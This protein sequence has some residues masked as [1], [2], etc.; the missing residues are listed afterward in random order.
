MSFLKSDL[1]RN[2]AIGFAAGALMLLFQIG[3]DM[4]QA[5]LP[6]AAA[7]TTR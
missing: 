6:E 4:A 2:F 5:A 3:P 7:Q 1:T